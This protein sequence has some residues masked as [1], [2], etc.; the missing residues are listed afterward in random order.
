MMSTSRLNLSLRAILAGLALT[1]AGSTLA[2]GWSLQSLTQ[3]LAQYRGGRAEFTETKTLAML[4]KPIESSGELRFAAPDF[5]QMRT[6]KPKPQTLTLMGNQLTLDMGGRSRQFDLRDHPD[7]ATLID[8]IRATL[9]GDLTTL[10][11]HYTLTLDGAPAHWTLTLVPRNDKAREHVRDI[12]I[13][14]H[15]GVVKT[16]TVEQA[17][18]DVSVM[19]ITPIGTP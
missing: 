7:I 2:A 3:A 13:G 12:R 15:E 5:L 14:G 6:V 4:D 8:G 9:N 11:K 10:Q 16:V 19:H 17:D 18:G 1:W